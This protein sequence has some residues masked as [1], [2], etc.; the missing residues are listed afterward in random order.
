VERETQVTFEEAKKIAIASDADMRH[1]GMNK[2]WIVKKL[3]KESD[4]LFACNPFNH[5]NYKFT[6]SEDDLTRTD[7]IVGQGIA[8]L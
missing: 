6:P 2:G 5:S 3:V 4:D 7:W 8:A 1:P